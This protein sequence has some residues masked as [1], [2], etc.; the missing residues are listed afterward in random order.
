MT[1]TEQILNYLKKGNKITP[2]RSSLINLDA[3]D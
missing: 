2:L 1:Q 3:L